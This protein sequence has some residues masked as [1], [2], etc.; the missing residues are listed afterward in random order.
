[1]ARVWEPWKSTISVRSPR[2]TGRINDS[3]IGKPVELF[4][5]QMV[6]VTPR[7]F[8][9]IG[10]MGP[11]EVLVPAYRRPRRSMRLL[12]FCLGLKLFLRLIRF[13]PRDYLR[14]REPAIALPQP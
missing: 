13:D 2:D 3:S 8:G 1:M 9:R 7:E 6:A 11:T 10:R 5:F 14:N 4:V 12:F